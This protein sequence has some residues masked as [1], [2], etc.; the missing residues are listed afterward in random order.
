MSARIAA[1]DAFREPQR[2][3][4]KFSIA[5][6]VRE[7]QGLTGASF[8]HQQKGPASLQALSEV[9]RPDLART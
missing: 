9:L 4:G 2:R 6:A 3:S 5:D 1:H 7:D 8:R